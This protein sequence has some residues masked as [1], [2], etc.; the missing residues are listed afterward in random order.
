MDLNPDLDLKGK[1][2]PEFGLDLDFEQSK[3]I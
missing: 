1:V 3:W 2:A